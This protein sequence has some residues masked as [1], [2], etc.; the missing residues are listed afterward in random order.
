MNHLLESRVP[1]NGTLGSEGGGPQEMAAFLPLSEQETAL[2]V[3]GLADTKSAKL[4]LGAPEAKPRTDERME[5][6]CGKPHQHDGISRISG[7][8]S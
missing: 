4:Q 3:R 8:G 6:L 5:R 1:E 2:P 7:M